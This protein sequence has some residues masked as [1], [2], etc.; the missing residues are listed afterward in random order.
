MLYQYKEMQK[1]GHKQQVQKQEQ[2]LSL[3]ITEGE[4]IGVPEAAK[5]AA[6]MRQWLAQD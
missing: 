1:Q 6:W 4:Y 3:S 5:G 2:K